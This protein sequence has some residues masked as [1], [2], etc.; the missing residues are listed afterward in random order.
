MFVQF[1][2][3]HKM[4]RKNEVAIITFRHFKADCSHY[5]DYCNSDRYLKLNFQNVRS[6]TER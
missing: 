3:Q 2:A 5:S 6:E 4:L 1:H